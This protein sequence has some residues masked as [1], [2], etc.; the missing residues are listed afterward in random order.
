MHVGRRRG[1][2]LYVTIHKDDNFGA[3]LVRNLARREFI[4][5]FFD[6]CLHFLVFGRADTHKILQFLG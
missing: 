2:F 1:A 6:V 3:V 5:K 4:D